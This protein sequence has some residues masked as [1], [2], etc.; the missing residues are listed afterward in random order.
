MAKPFTY[1]IIHHSHTDIGYTDYQEKIEMYHV[2][3][4]REAIDILNAAHSNRP[5]W[6]GFKWNCESYWCVEKFLDQADEAYRNDFYKYVESGEIGLSGSYLNLTELV[7]GGTLFE[8]GEKSRK[9]LGFPMRSAMTCDINGYSWGFADA[10]YENGTTRLLSS[11][12]AHHGYHPVWQRQRPFYWLSPK[13]NR[14]LCWNGEHYHLGNELGFARQSASE[15]L[16][17]DGLNL[18]EP[19]LFRRAEIRIERYTKDLLSRGYEYDFA[20]VNVSGMKIDNGSPN[21]SIPDFCRLYNQ[22]HGNEIFLKMVTLDEFFDDLEAASVKIPTYSGDWTDWWSDGIGSTPDVVSHARE[23]GRK[24]DILRNLDPGHQYA[25]DLFESARDDLMMYCEHTWGFSAS[26]SKPWEPMVSGLD[27][28]KMLYAA[29]AN[30]SASRA[31]DCL[32]FAKGETPVSFQKD[33]CFTVINP[34]KHSVFDVATIQN[35]GFFGHEKFKLVCEETGEE[36]P[37]QIGKYER[38]PVLR[39]LVSLRPGETLHLIPVDTTDEDRPFDEQKDTTL[40]ET[41]FWRIQIDP[42]LGI[43]LI[44]DKQKGMELVK[45]QTPYPPFTPI[46]EVTPIDD[47]GPCKVR[48]D[49]DRC[50]KCKETERSCGKV[51]NLQI[52]EDGPLYTTLEIGYELAGCRM[53]SVVLTV[54]KCLP[55]IDVDFRLHKE[56]RWEPENLYL[57]LPFTA[58]EDETFWV[59]KTGAVLRPRVDQLPGT[60][61]DYYAIQSGMAFCGNAGSVMIAT[62]DTPLISMGPLEA[63]PTILCGEKGADNPDEVYAWVMNNFWETN[64]KATLGGFHQYRYVLLSS[65]DCSPQKALDHTK[66]ACLGLIG[67]VSFTREKKS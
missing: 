40:I 64:F 14:I 2:L 46:Y 13:G 47:R 18:S 39:P 4:I 41:P 21:A 36:I 65:C 25:K 29:R 43:R 59:D 22:K 28:R 42:T 32:T 49:M 17:R 54:Y 9:H 44:F 24:L 53:C 35:K 61:T 58:G 66:D 37:F 1:Y 33:F 19:D 52:W 55:R 27:K 15:R 8:M 23:A 3:Y 38:G 5:E 62:P 34:T 10:L 30:E 20:P 11:T 16:I 51:A 48:R 56:S 67:F 60:C 31:L 6:L 12:H 63:R 50:R 45:K 57:S 26:V 7:D